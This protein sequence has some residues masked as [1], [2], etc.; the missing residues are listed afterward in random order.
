MIGAGPHL[1]E[2]RLFDSYLAARAGEAPDPPAAEHLADCAD[3]GAR[4][5]ELARFMDDLRSAGDA[6][7]EALFP[8]LR[9]REQHQQIARRIE[10]VERSARVITFPRPTLARQM[11]TPRRRALPSWV[12]A[13]AAAGLVAGVA[14]GLFFQRTGPAPL[15]VPAASLTTGAPEPVTPA[16]DAAAADRAVEQQE[17]FMSEIDLAADRPRTAELAAYDELTPHIREVSF[18]VS[19]R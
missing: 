11:P 16:S 7:V 12:A 15:V 6:E 3:C 4:Y 1:S 2:E 10:Q 19:G 9:L 17:L 5:Q 13:T 8:D 14:A 18:Q